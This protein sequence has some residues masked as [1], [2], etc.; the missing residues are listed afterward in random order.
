MNQRLQNTQ[1]QT[2]E[3]RM[4]KIGEVK[5]ETGLH[6][7]TIRALEEK[8]LIHP[9]RTLTGYRLFTEEDIQKIREIYE[10]KRH[11]AR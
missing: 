2:Q 1:K 6:E 7:N 11:G 5:R 4:K 10:A 8:G 3:V 9:A